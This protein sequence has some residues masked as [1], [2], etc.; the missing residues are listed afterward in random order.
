[1]KKLPMFS[2]TEVKSVSD[3]ITLITK[4]SL[5]ITSKPHYSTTTERLMTLSIHPLTTIKQT[6]ERLYGHYQQ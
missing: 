6:I 1:M 5:N 4:K 3:T 2:D